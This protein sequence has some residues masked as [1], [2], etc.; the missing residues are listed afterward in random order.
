VQGFEG[1]L[2]DSAEMFSTDWVNP[3]EM[4]HRVNGATDAKSALDD[5]RLQ[6]AQAERNGFERPVHVLLVHRIY[7]AVIENSGLNGFVGVRKRPMQADD[8]ASIRQ[9]VSD[10]VGG[11]LCLTGDSA[12]ILI[13]RILAITG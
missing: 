1:L 3:G 12:D 6:L 10:A 2:F 4:F 5:I 13:G 7:F 9:A 8:P 11:E